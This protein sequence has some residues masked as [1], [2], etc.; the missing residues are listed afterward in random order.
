[1]TNSKIAQ[2]GT[3]DDTILHDDFRMEVALLVVKPF[4]SRKEADEW[5][6]SQYK[7]ESE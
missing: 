6:E 5:V 2:I 1:V 7:E 4:A 3:V